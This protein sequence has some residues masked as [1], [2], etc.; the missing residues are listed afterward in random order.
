MLDYDKIYAGF[1]ENV[2]YYL[3]HAK[4]LD[5]E[6]SYVYTSQKGRLIR[7][8][9]LAW[10]LMNQPA[11]K[12]GCINLSLENILNLLSDGKDEKRISPGVLRNYMKELGASI[13]IKFAYD[14]ENGKIFIKPMK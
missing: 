9:N 10:I 7:L 5:Q 2:G 1:G 6:H 8:A 13:Q 4:H 3:D 14:T 12:S 11:D